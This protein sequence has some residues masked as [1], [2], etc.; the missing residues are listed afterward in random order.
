MLNNTEGSDS[1]HENQNEKRKKWIHNQDLILKT[2]NRE[3]QL[4]W[5]K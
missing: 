1:R 4:E 5:W 2:S 3:V